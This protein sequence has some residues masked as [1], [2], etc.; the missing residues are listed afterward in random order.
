MVPRWLR[1]AAARAVPARPGHGHDREPDVAAEPLSGGRTDRRHG[2]LTA[3]K[4]EAHDRTYLEQKTTT[5]FVWRRISVAAVFRR[6]CTP[7]NGATRP[8]SCM[9]LFTTEE[10]PSPLQ[11]G[12][13]GI[14]KEHVIARADRRPACQ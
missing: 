1:V 8:A 7:L 13:N 10:M 5:V 14:A 6:T 2:D 9:R 12:R 3:A 4:A 11:N